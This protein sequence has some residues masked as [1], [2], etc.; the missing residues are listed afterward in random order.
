MALYNKGVTLG[1]LKRHQEALDAYDQALK[2]D[3]KYKKALYNKSSTLILLDRL[4]EALI[5]CNKVLEIN[6]KDGGGF[7][8]KAC[9]YARQ[10]KNIEALK[11]LTKAIKFDKTLKD[12]ARKDGDED[13]KILWDDPDFKLLV[14]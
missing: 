5:V 14:N 4:K 8:N 13:F 1:N 2:I 10:G 7:Y 6:P 3:P 11:N 12:R 9:I